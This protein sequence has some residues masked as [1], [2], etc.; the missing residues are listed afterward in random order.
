MKLRVMVVS[1]AP[2]LAAGSAYAQAPGDVAP[3]PYYAPTPRYA[4][5]PQP[6]YTPAPQPYYTPAPQPYYA[7]PPPPYNAQPANPAESVMSHRWA[8]G[9]SIGRLGMA[10]EGAAEGSE[11]RFSVGEISLRYRASRRIELE[12]SL[13][14]GREVLEDDK[15]GD[16]ATGSVALALRYR[17][18]PE[19]RWNW[20]LMGGIGGSVVA[21]HQS[22]EL[23]REGATRPLGMLGIGIERRFRRF[24]LQ[25]ELRAVGLGEREDAS[26]VT[27]DDAGGGGSGS[28]P[29]PVPRLPA[30]SAFTYAQSLEGGSFT[31][32]ASYYF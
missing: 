19:Q 32:G 7:P 3:Q 8:I 21:P 1:L 20:F 11:A 16:L 9:L 28:P 5:P 30:T 27:F 2:I 17:F 6:Y 29:K 4:Q 26:E 22:T 24:A 23:E 10:P 31:L 14:G 13:S 15:E 12:V 18:R 25:A